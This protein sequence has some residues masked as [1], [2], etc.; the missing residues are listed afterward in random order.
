MTLVAAGE[1]TVFHLITWCTQSPGN[2]ISQ[3]KI[4][5]VCRAPLSIGGPILCKGD[6]FSA[7]C[8]VT[9]HIAAVISTDTHGLTASASDQSVFYKWSLVYL[10]LL[11]H[12]HI[13]TWV[14]T[15]T[16]LKICLSLVWDGGPLNEILCI[17]L[18]RPGQ[19]W[20]RQQISIGVFIFI[21]H[22]SAPLNTQKGIGKAVM[23][24]CKLMPSYCTYWR[25]Q[26]MF[27]NLFRRLNL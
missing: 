12:C 16:Y 23:K 19:L 22:N 3:D 1:F 6:T 9:M 26:Q 10:S 8:R 2:S 24:K 18:I 4:C 13:K 20:I 14:F 21:S 11:A 15:L 17:I 27:V 25:K 7:T 5:A